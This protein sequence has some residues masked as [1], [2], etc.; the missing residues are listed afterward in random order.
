[1]LAGISGEYYLRLEQG[2]ECQPSAGSPSEERLQM[3]S[4]LAALSQ[5]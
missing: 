3:L 1:M 2:R 5:A 4:G